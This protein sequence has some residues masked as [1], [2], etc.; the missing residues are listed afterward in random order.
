MNEPCPFQQPILYIVRHENKID[1]IYTCIMDNNLG[2]GNGGELR[3]NT[4]C[5]VLKVPS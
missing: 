5:K 2:V 4:L 1:V 3:L